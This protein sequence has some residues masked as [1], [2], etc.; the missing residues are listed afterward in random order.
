MSMLQTVTSNN[1]C[2]VIEKS[3][4]IDCSKAYVSAGIDR[5]HKKHCAK[6]SW[7]ENYFAVF[8]AVFHTLYVHH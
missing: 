5:D 4:V 1:T 6:E 8:M 2:Y 3:T 7:L